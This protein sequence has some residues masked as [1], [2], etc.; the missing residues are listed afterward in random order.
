MQGRTDDTHIKRMADLLRQGATLTDLACPNCSSPLFR[1]QD[2]TLWCGKDQKK[3]IIVKEG[4]ETPKPAVNPAMDKLEA[5]LMTKMQ[6]LQD[7]IEKTDDVQE[8][9]KL[10][11][12]LTE[13]LNS[14]EK[15]RKMK[16]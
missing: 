16:S 7:K 11:A 4:E 6:S 14:L 10:T 5:T 8:L 13:L 2:G 1:L 15:I 3:V 9:G 12:A